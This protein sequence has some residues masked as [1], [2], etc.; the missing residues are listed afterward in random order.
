MI[1]VA[2]VGAVVHRIPDFEIITPEVSHSRHSRA[3]GNLEG[4]VVKLD[5]SLRYL[6][7]A[8]E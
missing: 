4:F 8:W 2:L 5:R 6:P 1:P 3:G 7:P